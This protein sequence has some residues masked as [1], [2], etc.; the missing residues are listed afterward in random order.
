M[1]RVYYEK[2]AQYIHFKLIQ[3]RYASDMSMTQKE[4][5]EK[6][7]K[8]FSAYGADAS[9]LFEFDDVYTAQ[10]VNDL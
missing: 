3:W 10:D 4:Y 8:M 9:D 7:E 5:N 1:K 2:E 6:K